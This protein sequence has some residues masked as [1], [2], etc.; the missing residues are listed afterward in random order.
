MPATILSLSFTS[1][2]VFSL[3]LDDLRFRD[4]QDFLHRV[5]ESFGWFCG[6]HALTL[7]REK[8]ARK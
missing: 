4:R 1:G 5:T 8:G 6:F 7:C 3:A 2:L